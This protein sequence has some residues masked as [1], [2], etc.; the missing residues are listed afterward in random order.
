M[1]MP[2]CGHAALGPGEGAHPGDPNPR[3]QRGPRARLVAVELKPWSSL[4]RGWADVGTGV[5]QAAAPAVTVQL[6]SSLIAA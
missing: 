6:S 5:P 1:P 3:F 4:R 2:L